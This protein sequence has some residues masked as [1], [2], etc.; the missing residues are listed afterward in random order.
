[1]DIRTELDGTERARVFLSLDVP[2]P[3]NPT[4]VRFDLQLVEGQ[5]RID[6]WKQL[7][8]APA[9]ESTDTESGT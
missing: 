3:E 4:T 7:F 5:W 2:S 8:V 6:H 9:D 1:M